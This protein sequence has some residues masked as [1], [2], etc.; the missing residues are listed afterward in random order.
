[1]KRR[2]AHLLKKDLQT[3]LAKST[4][5]FFPSSPRL[6][7]TVVSFD[8]NLE[9][10]SMRSAM[11]TT[12]ASSVNP[13]TAA[14]AAAASSSAPKKKRASAAAPQISMPTTSTFSS[15]SPSS[16]APDFSP[17]P[18]RRDLLSSIA[19]LSVTATSTLAA[20]NW[21]LKSR[22][23]LAA[24]SSSS[25]SSNQLRPLSPAA[26]SAVSAA[27]TREGGKTKAPVLLRLAFHDAAAFDAGKRDDGAGAN[28][29]IR[30]ELDRPESFGLKRGW[31]VVE[32]VAERLKKE[33]DAEAASLSFADLI[34][35]GGAWAVEATG[36]PK[37]LSLVPVGRV[38]AEAADPP[39]RL[40]SEDADAA[41]L[42]A[43]FAAKG[44]TPLDLVSLSGAHT[45]GSKGFGDPLTFDGTYYK[46]L[47]EAPW[48]K[49]GADEMATHIGLASD[50]ALPL[51]PSC[52]EIIVRFAAD[53]EAFFEAFATSYVKMVGLGV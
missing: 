24:P 37:L 10:T 43:S 6:S 35:L 14:A 42:I 40:P 13:K 21:L 44:L 9:V 34:A 16:S 11:L 46:T 32:A 12:R 7:D 36:G 28:G 29:S 38:D 15:A 41:Q 22:P 52:R 25:S 30:F 18:S 5:S 27:F 1:M 50:H 8:F 20:L 31:R 19:A 17:S 39:N 45:L 23:A 26:A 47:L 2:F 3:F 49:P 51:D 33:S 4:S 48:A 53:Q